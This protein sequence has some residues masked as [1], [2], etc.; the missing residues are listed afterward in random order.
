MNWSISTF[1][2]FITT[3]AFIHEIKSQTLDDLYQIFDGRE[4][5]VT[6]GEGVEIST[7]DYEAGGETVEALLFRAPSEYPLPAIILIPGYERTAIDYA[8]RG[9]FFA[10][11]GFA[12]I[13]IT[14]PG[15][16]RS[17]GASD[18]A[19]PNS[20]EAL[21]AGYEKLRGE[22]FIDPDRIA[23][24][25]YSQGALTAALSA[26]SG[27]LELAA[28]ILCS[29]IYDSKAAYENFPSKGLAGQIK[30]Q[31]DRD[32]GSSQE[33][34]D[35]RNALLRMEYLDHPLLIL[36]GRL[37]GNSPVEQAERLARQLRSLG[38][39]FRM[40]IYEG[41][42]HNLHETNYLDVALKFLERYFK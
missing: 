15:F 17:G 38:K 27:E 11:N 33:A 40:R 29:G 37:D 19:G 39:E 4:T 8:G 13:A 30:G 42:D 36:H 24:F 3:F 34:F 5:A 12:C 14:Q 9:L 23:L 7:Y 16:G 26:T 10:R 18:W 2:T 22:E 41:A 1:L 31:M 6:F 20:L 21:K 25:G 28:A 35:Q 32:I